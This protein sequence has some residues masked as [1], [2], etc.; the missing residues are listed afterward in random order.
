MSKIFLNEFNEV[1]TVSAIINQPVCV[2]LV[3]PEF[4]LSTLFDQ[5]GVPIC[6]VNRIGGVV[7]ALSEP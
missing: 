3:L 2:A 6:F 5:E 7:L 4:S 1:R